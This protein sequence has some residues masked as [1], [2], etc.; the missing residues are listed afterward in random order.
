MCRRGRVHIFKYLETEAIK[1]ERKTGVSGSNTLG[2]KPRRS[3][4]STTGP[5]SH[6]P[7]RLRQKRHNVD[8]GY[9]TSDGLDKRWSQEITSN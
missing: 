3:A 6:L 8:S 7:D 5:P 1:L 4:G 2:R 9:S